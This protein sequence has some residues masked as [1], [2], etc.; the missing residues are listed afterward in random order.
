MIV[1]TGALIAFSAVAALALFPTAK[2][3]DGGAKEGMLATVVKDNL[4]IEA[5]VAGVFHAEDKTR[6]AVEPK[7]YRGDLI[8]T[9]IIPEGASVKE[10]DPLLQLDTKTI[11]DAIEKAV[12]AVDDAR[13][14]LQKA[15]SELAVTQIDQAATLE[16]ILKELEMAERSHEAEVKNKEFKLDDK[17]KEIRNSENSLKDS[18][19]NFEQLK[20]LYDERELHTATETILVERARRQIEEAER[21]LEKQREKLEHFKKYELDIDAEKKMLEIKKIQAEE[22]KEKVSFE[23]KVA[24]KQAGVQ[25]AQREFKIAQDKVSRLEQDLEMLKVLSPRNGIVFYGSL[26]DENPLGDVIISFGGGQRNLRVGG[27]V[28]THETLLTI[29]SMEHLSVKMQVREND[30]Q[31]M[32]EGLPITLRPDAFPD[33]NIRG[34]VTKVEHIASRDEFMS[35]VRSF[36]VVGA[37]EGVHPQL[38]AGMNCRVTIHVDTVA[39][40]V[41]VPV[42]SVFAEGGQYYCYVQEGDRPVKREVKIATSNGKAVQIV[43]GLRPGEKVYLYNPFKG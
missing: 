19:I 34:K 11:Q 24:E 26:T 37:Y 7:E 8:I 41:Q 31:H 38:R 14:A 29:A 27:R 9:Q 17:L 33:L 3:G 23:T 25:K 28:Q 22:K 15:E 42:V 1:K 18:R 39:E 16:R 10:G 4:S 2:T 32:K 21:G 40:A 20:K 36:K 30:I 12:T 5:Q 6:I 13:L 35:A 43:E